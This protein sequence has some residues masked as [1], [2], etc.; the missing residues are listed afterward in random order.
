L[1]G[2]EDGEDGEDE[3]DENLKGD[4]GLFIELLGDVTGEPARFDGSTWDMDV[5]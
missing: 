5:A 4:A 1:E 3:E 2:G